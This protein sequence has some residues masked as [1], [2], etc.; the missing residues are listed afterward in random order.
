MVKMK[1]IF[2]VLC[3]MSVCAG[4]FAEGHDDHALTYSVYSS[5][6]FMKP[7]NSTVIKQTQN[8]ASDIGQGWN[9]TVNRLS[10]SFK[11]MFGPAL[12]VQ[13]STNAERAQHM[14][15][16]KLSYM[17]IKPAQWSVVRDMQTDKAGY[18]DYTQSVDG[19][20]VVF[21]RLSFR[22]TN[23][24]KLL[25]IKT[26]NYGEPKQG[27]MPSITAQDAMNTPAMTTDLSSQVVT[28][29]EIAQDWVWFPIPTANGYELH[30][31]WEFT[32]KGIRDNEM[33]MELVG[34]ID[35]TNG[36]LLYRSN[37]VNET[38]DVTVKAD[39]YATN[40]LNG[41]TN[42][43]LQDMTIT[44]AGSNY[45][46]DE[47]GFVSVGSANP[48][49]NVTYRLNGPWVSVQTSGNGT[50][51]STTM[52]SSGSTYDFPTTNGSSTRH[53]TTFYSVNIVHDFMKEL[54]PGFTN[55]DNPLTANLDLPGNTCNAF[56]NGTINFYNPSGGGCRAFSEVTDIIYHEYGHGI[57]RLFYG[58]NG[59]NFSN[60]A[61]G[62]ANSDIWAIGINKDGVVGEGA[63][64]N[65]GNIRDYTGAAKVFPQ[66]LIGQV[67]NDGEII[68]GAW[69]DVAQNIGSVD[70]MVQIFA[71]TQYDLPN[72]PN[73]TEGEVYHD[74]LISALLNDDD[75]NNLGNGSPHFQEIVSA[76]ARHGIYLFADAIIDHD[77]IPN[78]APNTA[79]NINAKLTLTNA[80]FF[81]KLYLY[82]SN[83]DSVGVWDS[84]QMVDNGNLNF[85]AQIPAQQGGVIM[86][87][88]FEVR[89]AIANTVY[90][91]PS[92]FDR[93]NA[94]SNEVTIPF[95]FGVGINS[96]RIV[97]DF[98][99]PLQDWELGVATD[100]ATAGNWIQAVPVGSSVSGAA[101]GE[102][103]I[104]PGEDH[105]SGTGQ[106]LVTGNAIT[107]T[108]QPGAEDVDNGKTT[109]ATPLFQ[110]PFYEPVI[111]Y[112]RWYSND[113][114]SNSNA[115]TDFWQ[116]QINNGLSVIWQNV[117][118]TKQAEQK[119][120]RRIFK[121]GEYWKGASQ[122]RLRFI[123]A[124][125]ERS[126]LSNDGQDIVEAA[127]DDFII[128]E[129]APLSVE[130]MPA[131]VTSR[132]YP[133]PANNVVNVELPKG[134][135][136]SV[137]LYD[138]TGKVLIEQTVNE[139]ENKYS[140]NTS[141]LA[142]GTY[143]VLVQ[144][145]YAVQNTK[146]VVSHN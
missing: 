54:L 52:N 42:E 73:G 19:H 75:D 132:V 80:A 61:L 130:N 135:K 20:D 23:D 67:H 17:G 24:G 120:R 97:V 59:A 71:A 142:P 105:T 138:I 34:Y 28:S 113:R 11:D 63:F 36:E 16:T 47:N 89:E 77:D 2:S 92:G 69:W 112:F 109:A 32:V 56:Y 91:L 133:N 18:V 68:A 29:R 136:G 85:S 5:Y 86:D 140:L 51:F 101:P 102:G 65:G 22:F 128:Y 88:Y 35:A 10:G 6:S 4:A 40:P 43:P 27:T 137:S 141:S 49:A 79:I 90:G 9:I 48:P 57:S 37:N 145:Q 111:E 12:T 116:V 74:V 41:I 96:P 64:F 30:P 123:A 124:D 94:Q 108:S 13:G 127:V 25:R 81:D 14:M 125:E 53:T 50:S 121:V 21:S 93:A 95:Q 83:R 100:N 70:T 103:Q 3:M 72:G 115:R 126:N 99:S 118:Y 143:M 26:N 46:T 144:T 78:P 31:A 98:E 60:G 131:D 122:I 76:F 134:S 107:S 44:V 146:V 55:M 87:Y 114:G 104:Q 66:D 33:P 84:V 62:E 1:K 45:T 129:G 58:A 15:N 82:Y 106:C 139:N 119:W 39:V 8:M 117:E 110:L 7:A 38:F